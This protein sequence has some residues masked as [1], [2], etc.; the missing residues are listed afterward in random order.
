MR[1]I[2]RKIVRRALDAADHD[3]SFAEVRLR[4]PG[5]MRQRHEHLAAAQLR[6]PQVVLHDRV[7]AGELM[8]FL[9]PLPDTLRRVPLLGRPLLVVLQNGV[10]HADPG[11]ELRPLRSA[12]C[13]L[14]YPGGTENATIFRT[15]LRE[16]PNS[17]AAVR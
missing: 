6:R 8:L 3:Q 12:A 16:I 7:A 14:R 9:Q 17:R 15:D 4:L 1:K 11:V 13:S 10:E 2:H 5:W